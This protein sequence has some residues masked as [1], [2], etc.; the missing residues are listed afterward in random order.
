VE[1]A[2]PSP[3]QGRR[4][5]LAALAVAVIAVAGTAAI[6]AGPRLAACAQG[7]DGLFAC[8]GRALVAT[9]PASPGKPAP[10]PDVAGAAEAGTAPA[11]AP[12]ITLLRVE[13]DGSV[14]IAGTGR[15]GAWIETFSNGELLGR[16]QAEASGDWAVVPALPLPSG[17]VEITVAETGSDEPGA[18]SFVVVI[19]P[20]REAEPLVVATTPGQAGEVLQGL[21]P[22]LA[23][24]PTPSSG[25]SAP[26]PAA[27]LP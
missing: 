25:G 15:P 26:A 21:P 1:L 10:A 3:L 11:G 9:S 18:Q 22:L 6:V 27:L 8:L 2:E 13:P 19:D 4:T 7:A 5:Y 17:G 12:A 20:E 16:V 14:V 23:G 24:Q